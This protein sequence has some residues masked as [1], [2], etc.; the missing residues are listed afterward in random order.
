MKKTE[1]IGN[2]FGMNFIA[3]DFT[4]WER[5]KLFFTKPTYARDLGYGKDESVTLVFKQLGDT[6]YIVDEID[7]KNDTSEV[8]TNPKVVKK[9]LKQGRIF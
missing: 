1:T 8:K 4:L 9:G 2:I 7:S 3:R 5:I 6:V